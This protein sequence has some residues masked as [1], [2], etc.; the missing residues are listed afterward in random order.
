MNAEFFIPHCYEKGS[1]ENFSY[2]EIL[3][4][5]F[6]IFGEFLAINF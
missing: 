3:F 6:I 1:D 2:L 4:A 5:R